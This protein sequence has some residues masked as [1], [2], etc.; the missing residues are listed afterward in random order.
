MWV[1]LLV[2]RL[3][4]KYETFPICLDILLLEIEALH[5][6]F[7]RTIRLCIAAKSKSFKLTTY[8][9]SL[10]L[11]LELELTFAGLHVVVDH[12]IFASIFWWGSFLLYK[13]WL[14]CRRCFMKVLLGLPELTNHIL[15]DWLLFISFWR[16]FKWV[17]LSKDRIFEI[18]KWR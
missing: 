17:C 2:W 8:L 13:L 14:F 18:R 12:V 10:I 3:K 16:L 5:A 11:R 7:W 6:F 1:H 9:F 4:L 15:K